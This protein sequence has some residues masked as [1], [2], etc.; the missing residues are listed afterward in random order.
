MSETALPTDARPR[1]RRLR[2]ALAVVYLDEEHGITMTEK[3][4]ANRNA[5]GLGPFP[6]YL[7]TIPFYL[8]EVLDAWAEEAFT[9]ESPVAM[10]RRKAARIAAGAT[11]GKSRGLPRKQRGN[12]EPAVIDTG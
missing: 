5:S 8:V 9:P 1:T 4:L 3:T 7:G 6:E 10:T 11:E 2:R 12:A